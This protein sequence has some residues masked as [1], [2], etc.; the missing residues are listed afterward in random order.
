MLNKGKDEILRCFNIQLTKAV[1]SC[2]D[3]FQV[4][5]VTHQLLSCSS[6]SSLFKDSYTFN[7]T[8]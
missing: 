3:P 6:S 5:D 4:S 8:V 1:N 2:T 7:S